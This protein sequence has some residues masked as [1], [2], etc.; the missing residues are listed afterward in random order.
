MRALSSWDHCAKTWTEIKMLKERR[1][2]FLIIVNPFSFF[3][4]TNRDTN[5]YV[6]KIFFTYNAELGRRGLYAVGC[7]KLLGFAFTERVI[8]HDDH[9]IDAARKNMLVF[10]TK[11]LNA[12]MTLSGPNWLMAYELLINTMNSITDNTTTTIRL[13]SNGVWLAEHR[14][15][16]NTPNP[17]NVP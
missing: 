9:M 12:N 13:N 2:I 7:S 8:I 17:T 10:P 14:V 3:K 11:S 16:R 4:P 1:I 5:T 15:E 6:S